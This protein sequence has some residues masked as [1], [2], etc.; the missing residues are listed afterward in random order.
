MCILLFLKNKT[1]F[2]PLQVHRLVSK[3]FVEN[4]EPKY[5]LFVEHIDGDK[6]NNNAENLKWVYE[7]NK[8]EVVEL[9][10]HEQ[11]KQRSFSLDQKNKMLSIKS[12]K[13]LDSHQEEQKRQELYEEKKSK[14]PLKI[15]IYLSH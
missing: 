12:K 15:V 3:H 1:T 11:L 10:E 2:L 6:T 5:K 8:K 7:I 14:L 9:N 13:I 4:D